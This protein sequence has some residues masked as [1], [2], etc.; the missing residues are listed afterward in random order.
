LETNHSLSSATPTIEGKFT[1]HVT[2][3]GVHV[4][5]SP[6]QAY[7]CGNPQQAAQLQAL[8]V[9]SDAV[10]PEAIQRFKDEL[11]RLG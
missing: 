8:A 2:V 9:Y 5:G 1:L 3:N 7:A 6:Y 10:F 11:A 4:L